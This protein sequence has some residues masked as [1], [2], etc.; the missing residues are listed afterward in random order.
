MMTLEVTTDEGLDA[1]PVGLETAKL[2]TGSMKFRILE[3]PG[4][5]DLGTDCL[6][7]ARDL[8]LPDTFATIACVTTRPCHANG[9]RLGFECDGPGHVFKAGHLVDT[10]L[11]RRPFL[12]RLHWKPRRCQ[13]L[14]Q[15]HVL[16]RPDAA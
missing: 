1:S 11:T 10:R 12:S 16:G 8:M 2:G 4:K 6:A 15:K 5:F 9:T 14:R 3:L 7:G 13:R